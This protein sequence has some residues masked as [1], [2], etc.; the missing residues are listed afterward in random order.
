MRSECGGGEWRGKILT[1]EVEHKD[2]NHDNNKEENLQLLCPNCHSITATYRH[3]KHAE[4]ETQKTNQE[5][6]DAYEKYKS[7]LPAL[8]SLGLG[9]GHGNQLRMYSLV[10]HIKT[11]SENW[12]PKKR[13]VFSSPDDVKVAL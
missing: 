10:K 4:K 2:G 3:S 9:K 7:I 6:I 1:L 12:P 8:R 13:P 5:F 11:K